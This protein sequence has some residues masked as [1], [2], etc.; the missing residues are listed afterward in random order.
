MNPR[1]YVYNI[2]VGQIKQKHGGT[3]GV[4]GKSASLSCQ[5]H[6]RA[7]DRGKEDMIKI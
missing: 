4:Q 1:G 7:Q 5:S 2:P 6:E 3:K